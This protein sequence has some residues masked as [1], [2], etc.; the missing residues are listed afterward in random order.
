MAIGTVVS[1]VVT[2]I[3]DTSDW[4]WGAVVLNTVTGA[5]AVVIL[6]RSVDGYVRARSGAE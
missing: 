4:G 3:R 2:M 5:A 6:V 1:V